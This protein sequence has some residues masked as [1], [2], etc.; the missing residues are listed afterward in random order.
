MELG[1]GAR[2]LGSDRV[3]VGAQPVHAVQL[4][5]QVLAPRG[6]DLVVEQ[7]VAGVLRQR[8]L[9]DVL[10]PQRGQDPDHDQ[11]R[12]D[13]AGAFLGV[14]ER[15]TDLGLPGVR[16]ALGQ[17]AGRDVDL[18]IEAAQLG[19][20]G[21]VRD[22]LQD[23]V[24]AHRGLGLVVD[25]VQLDLQPHLR[26]L[27]LEP[28]LAQHLREHVEVLLHLDPVPAAVLAGEDQRR[29][30]SSHRPSR[31]AGGGRLVPPASHHGPPRTTRDGRSRPGSARGR[32]GPVRGVSAGAGR[33]A[34]QAAQ[35]P[36]GVP[37]LALR[38]GHGVRGRPAPFVGRPALLLRPAEVLL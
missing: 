24:V 31:F 26:P 36:V 30:V 20:P 34:G 23:V 25:E 11:M 21:R 38:S 10:L 1:A 6:E 35:S 4:D 16:S 8:P 22:R 29:D 32:E 33:R 19:G 2:G 28:R 5:A 3:G 12:A 7:P 17:P 37:G 9:A 15:G 14:I 13:R 18:Q 27:G